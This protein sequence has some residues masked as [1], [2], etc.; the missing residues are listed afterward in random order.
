MRLLLLLAAARAAAAAATPADVLF[1]DM[2]AAVVAEQL[3]YEEQ[4]VA[5]VLGPG[6]RQGR[7]GADADA[8]R[9][10]HEL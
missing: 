2:D 6:Q 4:L 7:G 9:G 5:F 8:E 1:F 3:E 10:L